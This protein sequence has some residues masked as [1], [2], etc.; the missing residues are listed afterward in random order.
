MLLVVDRDNNL[1][2]HA[3]VRDAERHLET[4][5]V[6]DGEYQFCDESGQPYMGEVLKPVGKFSS[7]QFRIVPHGASDSTLPLS[8]ISRSTDHRSKSRGLKTKEEALSY[9]ASRKT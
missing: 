4:I 7:G 5:D 3:S 2:I 9:F 6:E 1:S 8:F